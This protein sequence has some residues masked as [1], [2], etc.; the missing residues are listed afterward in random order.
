MRK[1]LLDK[2]LTLIQKDLKQQITGLH[3]L[4]SCTKNDNKFRTNDLRNDCN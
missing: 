1:A 2:E 3:N 4:M